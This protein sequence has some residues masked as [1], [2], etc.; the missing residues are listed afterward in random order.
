MGASPGYGPLG[1]AAPPPAHAPAP[2]LAPASRPPPAQAQ[3]APSVVA[4]S[5]VS[6]SLKG[7][8]VAQAYGGIGPGYSKAVS[9]PSARPT[10]YD[11]RPHGRG[12]GRGGQH[13]AAAR[14]D[15]L[16]PE[17]WEGSGLAT[18]QAAAAGKA[19]PPGAV[20]GGAGSASAGARGASKA[21]PSPGEIL[22]MNAAAKEARGE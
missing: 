1:G 19:P 12:R 16:D 7:A 6:S 20:G 11:R 4:A 3:H 18:A 22:R 21:L 17:A 14:Y 13:A 9:L 8:G 10:P 5:G 15:P 2:A